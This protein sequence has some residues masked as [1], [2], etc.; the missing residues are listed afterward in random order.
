[1]VWHHGGEHMVEAVGGCMLTVYMD[2][3]ELKIDDENG[4]TATVTTAD[5]DQSNGV[6]HV[7]DRVIL[8]VGQAG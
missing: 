7:I 8:P 3:D 6:V 5:V 4:R 1:M 2:G